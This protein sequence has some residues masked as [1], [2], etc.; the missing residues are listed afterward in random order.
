MM[1]SVFTGYE[2]IF[3]RKKWSDPFATADLHA[4]HLNPVAKKNK[5]NALRAI[6]RPP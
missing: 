4:V 3:E 6:I 1:G 5:R 2:M